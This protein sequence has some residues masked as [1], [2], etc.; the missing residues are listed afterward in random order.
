MRLLGFEFRVSR[1]GRQRTPPPDPVAPAQ[2]IKPLT[3]WEA[4]HTLMRL[5]DVTLP[6][7]G[8]SVRLKPP[9][10]R[11]MVDAGLTIGAK[12]PQDHELS[13]GEADI[14][15]KRVR[16]QAQRLVCAAVEAPLFRPHPGP[17]E[18]D[19][20]LMDNLDLMFLYGLLIQWGAEIFYGT[21]RV[22]LNPVDDGAWIEAQMQAAGIVDR[23]AQRYG[24]T[25]D[26]IEDM[27]PMTFSRVLAVAQ[28]GDALE[29]KAHPP[30]TP[31]GHR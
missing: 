20:A 23:I 27:D 11:V 9:T 8:I 17:G 14:H 31:G 15:M 12:I 21:H 3:P 5:R 4:Y 22:A 24:V 16:V 25:P 26:R 2:A 6:V 13:K 30:R 1:T 28:A 18:F 10:V 29:Q 7:A 19:I